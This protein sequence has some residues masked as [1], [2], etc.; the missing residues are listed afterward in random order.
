MLNVYCVKKKQGHYF[1]AVYQ[2]NSLNKRGLHSINAN[3]V[4]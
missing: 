3:L 4:S 2:R 1:K